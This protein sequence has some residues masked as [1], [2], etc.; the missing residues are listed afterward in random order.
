MTIHT[1]TPDTVSSLVV[2]N[3]TKVAATAVSVA[4]IA[5][6]VV[7]NVKE[8]KG[9]I[10]NFPC[11]DAR[12]HLQDDHKRLCDATIGAESVTHPLD[13]E[14]CALARFPWVPTQ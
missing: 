5:T 13:K 1:T 8:E 6:A 14:V 10:V 11:E 9:L 3:I 4:V 12:K 7:Q 2:A